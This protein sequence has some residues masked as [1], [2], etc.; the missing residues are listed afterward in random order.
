M[1]RDGAVIKTG[2]RPSDD[3][4]LERKYTFDPPIVAQKVSLIIPRKW[5]SEGAVH[6]R[7]D[8]VI[9]GPVEIE[10]NKD[11]P[12]VVK[13]EEDEQPDL[14]LAAM[15]LKAEYEIM[16][17]WSAKWKQPQLNSQ[18]GFWSAK[19]Y[20][21]MDRPFWFALHFRQLSEV[22]EIVFM[23]VKTHKKTDGIIK[24]FFIQYYDGEKWVYYKKAGETGKKSLLE[25]NMIDEDNSD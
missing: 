14:K 22:H 24:K 6:G 2:Q 13:D 16:N 3:S 5:R 20:P 21:K 10:T 25:T 7:L 23:L 9:K 11:A 19:K 17:W 8:Y 4:D 15:E 12:K 18:T 1:Y